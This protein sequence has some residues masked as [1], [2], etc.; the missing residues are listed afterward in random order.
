MKPGPS[1]PSTGPLLP[2]LSPQRPAHSPRPSH[3]IR[4]GP[5]PQR[6]TPSC[7]AS[8]ARPL[9]SRARSA[10]DPPEPPAPPVGAASAQQ[11]RIAA[12]P[13]LTSR[14]RAS[15]PSSPLPSRLRN[16]PEITGEV[17]GILIP[18][19]PAAIP[20]RPPLNTPGRT[21]GTLSTLAPPPSSS[22][23]LLHVGEPLFGLN[24][25]PPVT[26]GLI[27]LWTTLA[28]PA[29]TPSGRSSAWSTPYRPRHRALLPP[30]RRSAS[31]ST[32]RSF[33]GQAKPS[34]RTSA[35]P[36]PFC[37]RLDRP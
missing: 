17:A 19:R 7:A 1:Q 18:R 16:G 5:A 24:S 32:L 6:P 25:S 3:P 2:L 4:S 27:W 8:P 28:G 37:A 35:P 20:A 36:L 34:V 15:A 26:T 12:A 9:H 31:P 11:A 10:R 30:R 21:P 22:A 29:R 13:P 23:V 33:S 14:P